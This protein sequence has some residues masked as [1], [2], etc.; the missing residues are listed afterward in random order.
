MWRGQSVHGRETKGVVIVL[1]LVA[2]PRGA[3]L[4]FL[5]D[6]SGEGC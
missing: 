6:Y 4:L 5:A 1:A 2:F 3:S